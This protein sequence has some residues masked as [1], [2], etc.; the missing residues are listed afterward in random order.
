MPIKPIKKG[1]KAWIR[2]DN[3]PRFQKYAGKVGSLTKNSLGERV[4]KDLTRDLIRINYK[5]YFDF[6]LT[7]CLYKKTYLENIC[8]W[9]CSKKS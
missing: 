6:F 9:D 2:S 5:V 7:L 3:A 8:I 4:A 1:Y